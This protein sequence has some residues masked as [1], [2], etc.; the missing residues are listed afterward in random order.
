MVTDQGKGRELT[1]TANPAFCIT[2]HNVGKLVLA[3][4]NYGTFGDGFALGPT[5]DCITGERVYAG[6]YPKGSRTRY[7]FAAAFWIGAVVGRDTLVSTGADGWIPGLE[8]MFPDESPFGDMI[9][10]SITDPS[11]PGF[12]DAVSEQDRIAVYTDTF[13]SGVPGLGLDEVDQRPHRPLHIEVTQRSYA[14]SYPYAEDFVLFDY[15]I[16]NIGRERLRQVYMGVYVDA[17]V[18]PEGADQGG[19]DDDICGF[20]HT[21]TTK[22]G[23]GTWLDTINI[24]W[25][26][27]ND[28]DL[29][30]TN[31]PKLPNVTGTRIVRTPSDSLDVSFNWWVSN[32]DPS[33]DFGPQRKGQVRDLGHGG[34]GT[35]SG[36]RNKYYFMRNKEFDYDQIFTADIK[37]TDPDWEY[38]NQTI[39]EDISNGFDTRYLLS[40]GP[41]NI[42]PGQT[43]PLSLAYVGGENLHYDPDNL[44]NNLGKKANYRPHDF[45]SHLDFS[46]LAENA[47]WASW[48]YDNPGVDSDSDGY[49]GEYRLLCEGDVCDTVWYKGDGVPDFRG[50]SPP[51]APVVWVYP[52]VGSIRV[53]WNGLR[54]ETTRDVFSREYDF[55]GYR[56]YFARDAR[57]ASYSMLTSYDIEDYN[58]WVWN[59]RKREW[60]LN[61]IPF[62]L[63]QL[64]CLYA[65][66]CNDPYFEPLSFT[67]GNPYQLEMPVGEDSLFYF[68]PQDYNRS[69]LGVTTEI[70]KVYPDQP[71]PTNLNPDSANADEL[72]EDGYLKYFEY[73]YTV[74]GLLPTVPYYLNVTAFD[75]GSPK[76]NLKSLETSKTVNPKLTYPLP[77][78]QD[79]VANNLEVYTYPNPYKGDGSYLDKGFEGR[80]ADYIIPNRLRRIHFANLPAKCTIRIYTLDGDLVREIVHDMDPAD[81]MASHDEWDLITR[82]TQMVVSGIYYWTVED[83][84]GNTQV[85]KQVII[86]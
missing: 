83:P 86:M 22:Y 56:V 53:R 68:Q 34:L 24:A 75:Y 41:F 48:V 5:S 16:R 57:D 84:N 13:T 50:A 67:R 60:E 15:S 62:T 45:Y 33:R 40:F 64:K 4:T 42:D 46:D 32:G 76:S 14:W 69:E 70:H 52:Q 1:S 58:K 6:E 55:E 85:G 39:A 31:A 66:S 77:T 78:A 19:F 35:P 25:I 51:P 2:D 11:R 80:D 23:G 44:K 47:V 36:D 81:P 74:T 82:N 12:K 59:S 38:P 61:D 26:A 63:E 9:A 29:N 3:V 73:E 17:D 79:V 37:P 7:V 27:D 30:A 20:L 18:M 10:R 21:M 8:E 43:L 28:G 49:A 54:S 72:T 71:Y 65:D